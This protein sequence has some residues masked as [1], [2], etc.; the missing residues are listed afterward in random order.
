V[1]FSYVVLPEGVMIEQDGIT[2]CAETSP[3]R[4]VRDLLVGIPDPEVQVKLW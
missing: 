2:E 1:F 4:W 3:F